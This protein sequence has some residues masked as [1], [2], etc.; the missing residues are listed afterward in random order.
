[1]IFF[2]FE[3]LK[4]DLFYIMDNESVLPVFWTLN[5]IR[6]LMQL[7]FS[8]SVLRWESHHIGKSDQFISFHC[9]T[10]FVA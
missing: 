7:D 1:M 8:H 6:V 4:D 10:G 2:Q 9:S 3:F 5:N